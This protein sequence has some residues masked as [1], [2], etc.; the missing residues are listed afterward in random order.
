MKIYSQFGVQPIPE[1]FNWNFA[2]MSN[3]QPDPLKLFLTKNP[4]KG[5]AFGAFDLGGEWGPEI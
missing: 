4:S 1:R 2:E 3:I 5:G